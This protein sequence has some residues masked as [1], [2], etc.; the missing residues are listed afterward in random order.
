MFKHLQYPMGNTWMVQYY[1]RSAF[2]QTFIY[3]SMVPTYF[4]RKSFQIHAIPE[5]FTFHL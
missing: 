5:H 1:E 2:R 4:F 3:G